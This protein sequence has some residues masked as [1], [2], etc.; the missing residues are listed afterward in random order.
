MEKRQETT[1]ARAA[2]RSELLTDVEA[3]ERLG[4]SPNTL[5]NWRA[6]RRVQVP[7]VKI[8]RNVRYRA[9]DIEAFIAAHLVDVADAD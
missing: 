7:F 1:L 5:A 4:T 2:A 6:T 3:A 8:G 9:A